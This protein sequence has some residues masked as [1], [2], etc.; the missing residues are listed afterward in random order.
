[1]PTAALPDDPSLEQL[2]KQA[3]DLRDLAVAR[4]PGATLR[5]DPQRLHGD[6]LAVEQAEQ[7]VVLGDELGRGI[8][9]PAVGRQRGGVVVAVR[10]HEREASAGSVQPEGDVPGPGLGREESVGVEHGNAKLCI[11]PRGLSHC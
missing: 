3:K 5:S 8:R 9:E 7:V 4:V 1:L 10:A 6:A 2:K 11:A